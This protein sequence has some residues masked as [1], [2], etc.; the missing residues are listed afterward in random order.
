[1]LLGDVVDQ[2]HDDD[3]FAYSSAAEEADLSAFQKRLNQVD[4]FHSRLEHF[5][6]R[7]LFVEGRSEA[8]DGHSFLKGNRAEI[9]HGFADYVHYAAERTTAHGSGNGSALINRFHAPHHAV[10]RFHGNAAYTAFADVL[11][12]FEDDVDGEGTVKPS[13]TTRSAS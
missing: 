7:R 4:D 5:G 1:M 8:V 12:Y 6:G 13:L 3:G 10:G 9:V 2:L 11:L